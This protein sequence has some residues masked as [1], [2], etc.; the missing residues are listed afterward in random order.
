MGGFPHRS[1]ERFMAQ[2]QTFRSPGFFE[3]EIDQ[4][5]VQPI[6]PTGT[7]GGIISTSDKGP[8]FVP[9]TVA[10]FAD[11]RQRFGDLNIRKF[12]PYAANEFLKYKTAL[13]F[14]R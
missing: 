1:Q 8:A 11:Y 7:P 3:N 13:T 2:Q 6:G 10:S 5:V 9:V 4:S 14:L 12:G